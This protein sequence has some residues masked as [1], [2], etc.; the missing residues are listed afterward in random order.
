MKTS[1]KNIVFA[2]GGLKG[3][4][5]IG[6]IR[7]L[8][9]LVIRKDIENIIGVSIGSVF[10]LFY[11]LGIDYKTL[12]DFF[13]HL[14]FKKFMDI[15]IDNFLINQSIF[16]G[17]YFKKF[18]KELISYKVNPDITFNELTYYSKITFTV[19]ALNINKSEVKYFNHIRTPNIKVIDAIMA[20]CS[21][22]LV[23][24]SYKINDEYYY[25]GGICNNCPVDLV[26]E[27]GTIAFDFGGTTCC[28]TNNSKIK[29]IDLI[30]SIINIT[31]KK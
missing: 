15:D 28:D 4:A 23:F 11:L 20:S 1:L 6:T 3:W 31:N 19:N 2:G 21:L 22:P 27:L 5:Y 9:E 7:A 12:L 8:E 17:V 16:T 26:D 10:G 14:D 25:D 29:I 24:P 30:F 18:I 13:I